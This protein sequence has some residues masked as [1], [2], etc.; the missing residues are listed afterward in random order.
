MKIHFIPIQ[1]LIFFIIFINIFVVY[2]V[3][4]FVPFK[5]SSSQFFIP[6]P[7]FIKVYTGFYMGKINK[8]YSYYH[9]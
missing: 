6:H 9:N 4:K 1:I 3:N 7:F 8:K 2:I 5:P